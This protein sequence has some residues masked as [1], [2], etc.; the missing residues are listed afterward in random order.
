MFSK[1]LEQDTTY[2]TQLRDFPQWHRGVKYFGFWAIEVSNKDCID[3]IKKYQEYLKKE[4]HLNY[5]RQPHITL[6]TEGLLLD[7]YLEDGKIKK[8]IDQIMKS[9]IK[10]FTL[11]LTNCN[12]FNICPYLTINDPFDKLNTIRKY[13]NASVDEYNPFIYIPH[14]TLGFYN[15]IYKTSSI[16]KKIS[17]FNL[18]NIEFTVNEIVFAQYETKDIQGEYEVLY[19]IKLKD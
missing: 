19:R 12:S 4:L 18:P 10:S 8:K 1:F 11:Q 14:I 3:K 6:D 2:K 7:N 13:L 9:N 15:G 5:F 17:N 16:V